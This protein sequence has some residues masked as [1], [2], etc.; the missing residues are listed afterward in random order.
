MLAMVDQSIHPEI[1]LAPPEAVADTKV[2]EKEPKERE[3]EE[4]DRGVD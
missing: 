1:T 2:D 3:A 4:T